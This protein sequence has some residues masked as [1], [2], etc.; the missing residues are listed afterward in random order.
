VNHI[1]TKRSNR[2]LE[3]DNIDYLLAYY[4][5]WVRYQEQC[6]RAVADAEEQITRIYQAI[7]NKMPK[8]A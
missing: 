5:E 8:G 3:E 6:H 1:P 4:D 2:E 7:K